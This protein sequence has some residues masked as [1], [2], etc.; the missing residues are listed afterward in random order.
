M[1]FRNAQKLF[2]P[3]VA[4]SSAHDKRFKVTQTNAEYAAAEC[5]FVAPVREKSFVVALSTIMWC[6]IR[7]KYSRFPLPK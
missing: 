2:N 6:R 5:K 3:K 1:R 7:L 4:T